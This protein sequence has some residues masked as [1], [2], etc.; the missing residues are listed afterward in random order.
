MLRNFFCRHELFLPQINADERRFYCCA[1][2]AGHKITQICTKSA[3]NYN[4]SV[5]I[6]VLSCQ[7][8]A[9]NSAEGSQ[10]VSLV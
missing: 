9:P 5:F 4:L 8:V 6:R 10:F 7:F 3:L 1:I 2:F